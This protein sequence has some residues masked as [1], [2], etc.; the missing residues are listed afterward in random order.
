MVQCLR[1][2]GGMRIDRS[3][4][5]PD[6]PATRGLLASMTAPVLMAH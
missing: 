1:Q 6:Q 4:L 3:P 2:R 5:A